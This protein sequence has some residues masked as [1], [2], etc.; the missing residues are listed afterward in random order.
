MLRSRTLAK[1]SLGFLFVQRNETPNAQ[2]IRTQGLSYA[3]AEPFVGLDLDV[4]TVG[5]IMRDADDNDD[6]RKI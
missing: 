3:F 5:V 4:I 2:A 1:L 6:Y